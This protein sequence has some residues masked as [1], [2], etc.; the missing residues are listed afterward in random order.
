MLSSEGTIK[1]PELKLDKLFSLFYLS[2][3]TSSSLNPDKVQSLPYIFAQHGKNPDLLASTVKDQ[4]HRFLTAD[5]FFDSVETAASAS[6]Q[7]GKMTL[8][9]SVSVVDEGRTVELKKV[10]DN[11]KSISLKLA[12]GE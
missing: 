1:D 12:S 5:G 9:I 7:G 8:T 11:K 10:F 6:I 2:K 3:R 4:L